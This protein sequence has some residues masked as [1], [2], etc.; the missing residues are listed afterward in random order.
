MQGL[1]YP[2]RNDNCKPADK[3][4]L[5]VCHGEDGV[6]P[7][8]AFGRRFNM[9]YHRF[10]DILRALVF[11]DSDGDDDQEQGRERKPTSGPWSVDSWIAATPRGKKHSG[12]VTKS[13]LTR[14]CLPGTARATVLVD[15]QR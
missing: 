9:G 2:L 12:Q 13:L 6:F 10:E 15:C 3:T 4:K 14:A 5:L 1:W 8:P 11:S 7:A